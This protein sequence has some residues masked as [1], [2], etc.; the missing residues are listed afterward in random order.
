MRFVNAWA[1]F[2]TERWLL[3]IVAWILV[4]AGVRWF[5]P[6]WDSVTEDGDFQYLPDRC[7]SVS[8]QRLLDTRFAAVSSRSHM[9]AVVARDQPL[10]TDFDL[11]VASDAARR[12][13][14]LAGE[15]CLVRAKQLPEGSKERIKLAEQ[16]IE[17]FVVA[18]DF[19]QSLL[20][21]P[22]EGA[23]TEPPVV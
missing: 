2:V 3:V 21:R 11:A 9:V 13:E 15:S 8:G 16:A 19:T 4:V 6:A 7:S 14:L 12:I 1:K 10:G 18:L 23:I 5:A 20:K 17:H 22:P